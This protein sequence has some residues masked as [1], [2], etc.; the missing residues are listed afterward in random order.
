MTGFVEVLK[1]VSPVFLVWQLG[2]LGQ[3]RKPVK[4]LKQLI[5]FINPAS[6]PSKE[7]ETLDC[8]NMWIGCLRQTGPWWQVLSSHL[9]IIPPDYNESHVELSQSGQKMGSFGRWLNLAP[10]TGLDSG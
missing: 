9:Q 5:Y 7:T 2:F 4:V 1:V 8:S 10:C 3:D 6:V